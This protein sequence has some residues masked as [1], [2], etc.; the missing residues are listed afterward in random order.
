MNR[1]SFNYRFIN[2]YGNDLIPGKIHTIRENYDFWKKFEGRDVALFVW[3]GK[4]YRSK[5][6]VFCVK[7]IVSVQEVWYEFGFFRE[8]KKMKPLMNNALLA[9][10]DGFENPYNFLTWFA[11][12]DYKPG[13]MAVLHF[14]NFRY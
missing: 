4:P 6:H 13:R 3:E 9:L 11:D 10:N 1:I 14:T 12:G 2:N 5:Q 8:P 7:R